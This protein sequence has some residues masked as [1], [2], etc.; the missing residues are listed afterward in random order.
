MTEIFEGP[1]LSSAAADPQIRS[2]T[3][4]IAAKLPLNWP[5]RVAR[6]QKRR[7]PRTSVARTT[8]MGSALPGSTPPPNRGVITL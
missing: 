6:H 2:S 4:F 7:C 1:G 5:P 8:V 3:A